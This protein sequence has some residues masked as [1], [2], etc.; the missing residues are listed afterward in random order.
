MKINS[1]AD[2]KDFRNELIRR[3][4][5]VVATEMEYKTMRQLL[6]LVE[7][8]DPDAL[9]FY[10]Q[11]ISNRMAEPIGVTSGPRVDLEP[12]CLKYLKL[13]KSEFPHLKRRDL[14]LWVLVSFTGCLINEYLTKKFEFSHYSQLPKFDI[15]QVWV[16]HQ[17][18]QNHR[19]KQKKDEG[20]RNL[21][22]KE[23][24][25][26]AL[27]YGVKLS[28]SQVR[29]IRSK[30]SI[31]YA[32]LNDYDNGLFGGEV[33]RVWNQL[34]PY[35]PALSWSG[36]D[37]DEKK[38]LQAL[39]KRYAGLYSWQTKSRQLLNQGEHVVLQTMAGGGK[40]LVY[41]LS[42]LDGRF[43]L[44]VCPL[45]RLIKNQIR[46]IQKSF[47][48][49]RV[50]SFT[51]KTGAHKRKRILRQIKEGKLDMLYLT[52]EQLDIEVSKNAPET[53]SVL[54]RRV[55]LLVVDEAHHP[56][57][58][59][60]GFR[61]SYEFRKI[62]HMWQQIGEPQTLFTSAS[63]SSASHLNIRMTMKGE[64]LKV[65]VGDLYRSNVALEKVMFEGDT[66]QEEKL[67][68]LVCMVRYLKEVLGVKKLI[69][70]VN[71]PARVVQ[72]TRQLKEV[73]IRNVWGVHGYKD[74]KGV[75]SDKEINLN[76]SAFED[77]KTGV[78]VTTSSYAEGIDV[79]VGAVVVLDMP[80]NVETLYQEL[81]RTGHQ[82]QPGLGFVCVDGKAHDFNRFA[83]LRNDTPKV[84]AYDRMFEFL[85]TDKDLWSSLVKPFG[86][87][88]PGA[89]K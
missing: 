43:V 55:D 51:S 29:N 12:Y 40:S 67:A 6:N 68:W 5:K 37:P 41:L 76:Q 81:L 36:V 50:A 46:S 42:A 79:E 24:S 86:G 16:V 35:H 88:V 57:L 1:V 82:G 9:P 31:S 54:H 30:T 78:L 10:M 38:I 61:P 33:G 27:N 56:K 77:C 8:D 32:I 34:Q 71:Q 75:L 22:A 58:D 73:G 13:L 28:P 59:G 20:L 26:L 60:P 4:V 53:I 66:A 14:R 84:E 15:R 62:R 52:P 63:L 64:S 11:V 2:I 47:P 70:Y 48:G 3:R 7:N 65:V 49:L 23:I 85:D 25:T 18:E 80:L 89:K 45:V 74:R 39:P 21:T 17:I 72:V 87:K 44:V 69:V 83:L 19:D